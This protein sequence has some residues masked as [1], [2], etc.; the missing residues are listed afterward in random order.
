VKHLRPL[1]LLCLPLL[2]A[3]CP[4][5]S[6]PGGTAKAKEDAPSVHVATEPLRVRPMARLYQTSA[7]LR[8]RQRAAVTART[9]GVIQRYLV[10]E[11]AR[12]RAGAVLVELEDAEQKI[13]RDDARDALRDRQVAWE[14]A[15]QLFQRHALAQD[16]LREARLAYH[17]AKHRLERAE[18]ALTRTRIRAPF[19][20][21]VLV[22]HADPGAR[23]D[24]GTALLDLA[25]VT[26][27]EADVAV[28]ERHVP[29]LQVGQ[30]ARVIAGGA[31]F[32]AEIARI[33]P[34]VDPT[35]GTVKVTLR[36][37]PRV[38]LR[39][40]SFARVAVVTATHPRALVVPRSAILSEGGRT[41]LF[42]LL[43]EQGRVERV[44]VQ[45]GFEEADWIEV[46][47]PSLRAG[48]PIVTRGA[49]A[50]ADGAAV[51]WESAPETAAPA[52]TVAPVQTGE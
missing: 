29:T 47:E 4:D 44:T 9:R 46:S 52:S 45:T 15:E 13:E 50:L 38:S 22:R 42:R 14:R 43:P 24:D 3:G 51:T 30:A 12:V 19:A 41:H 36:A 10:E 18:L 16:A 2:A 33:A 25:D 1:L 23:V 34:Q 40:G 17:G 28:P 35:S 21:V 6:A 37:E 48:Q 11:G 49:A 7:R 5:A 27:L 20:G 39:P 32:A 31:T 26:P 8:A